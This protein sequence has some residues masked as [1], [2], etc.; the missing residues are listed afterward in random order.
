M[1]QSDWSE[2]TTMVQLLISATALF[3]NTQCSYMSVSI[4]VLNNLSKAHTVLL[5]LMN[6]AHKIACYSLSA[7]L[8]S[9][10]YLNL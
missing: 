8:Y 1:E 7:L 9:V 2:F 3:H 4:N 5:P 6:C 10:D